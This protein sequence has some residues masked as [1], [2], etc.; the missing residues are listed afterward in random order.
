MG[1]SEGIGVGSSG[2]SDGGCDGGPTP[3]WGDDFI[4][5]LGSS[6]FSGQVGLSDDQRGT[7]MH[8]LGHESGLCHGGRDDL[9]CKPNYQSVMSYTFHF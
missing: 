3:K 7:F 2:E 9:N 5:T 4:V 1:A 8:E 6:N